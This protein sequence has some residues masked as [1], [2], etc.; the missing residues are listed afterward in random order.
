MIALCFR[1]QGEIFII[2]AIYYGTQYLCRIQ[3]RGMAGHT[4]ENAVRIRRVKEKTGKG[5]EA[6]Q[7]GRGR[8][9]E[10]NQFDQI[11]G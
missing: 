4:G 10:K 3:L 8:P 9:V 5:R 6:G 11:G 1:K 2:Q 7:K